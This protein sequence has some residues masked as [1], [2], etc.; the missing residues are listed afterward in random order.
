M[1][2]CVAAGEVAAGDAEEVEGLMMISTVAV[3]IMAVKIVIIEV[4]V[5]V[6]M[7]MVVGEVDVVAVITTDM[8]VT[9]ADMADPQVEDMEMDPSVQVDHRDMAFLLPYLRVVLRC[10]RY[11]LSVDRALTA[12]YSPLM[13]A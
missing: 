1:E 4:E 2:I 7:M 3:A 12:D 8:M 6:M 10:V 9:V 13:T 11:H 5:V